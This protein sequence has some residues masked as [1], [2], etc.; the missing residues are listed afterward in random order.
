MH[1]S[2]L[3][4]KYGGKKKVVMGSNFIL[5]NDS[6]RGSVHAEENLIQKFLRIRNRC[7]KV[8][9]LIVK[10]THNGKIGSSRPCQNCMKRL[11]CMTTKHNISINN[12]Y[13]STS[14][15]KIDVDKFR[16]MKLNIDDFY[17][18]NGFT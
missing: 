16:N 11:I 10:I 4:G 7:Q 2:S 17:I 18:S 1:F 15:G 9:L 5:K 3:K 12:V 6:G 13:Y 14:Q 8:D